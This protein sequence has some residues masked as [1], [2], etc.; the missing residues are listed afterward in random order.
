MIDQSSFSDELLGKFSAGICAACS[1]LDA[2]ARTLLT[3][4]GFADIGV[5]HLSDVADRRRLERGL[6]HAGSRIDGRVHVGGCCCRS[7][8]NWQNYRCKH[9]VR[10]QHMSLVTEHGC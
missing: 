3:D 6:G 10:H 7:G 2:F 1:A 9:C 5:H 8:H 4:S